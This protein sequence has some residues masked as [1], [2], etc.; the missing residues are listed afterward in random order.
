ME[1]ELMDTRKTTPGWRLL[2][3]YAVRVGGATNHRL[4]LGDMLL[5]KNNHVDAQQDKS[6]AQRMRTALRRIMK[7]KA[8]KIGLEV[9]VRDLEELRAALEFKVPRIMLDNMND[10]KVALAVEIVRRVAPETF[11]EVSGGVEMDRFKTLRKLGVNAVSMGSLTSQVRSVDISLRLES[12]I[13]QNRYS[14][15]RYHRKHSSS[16]SAPSQTRLRPR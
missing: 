3:K 11:I 7:A 5:V 16:G 2:E 14:A 9:E 15:R 13:S 1:I 8:R 12:P 10:R 4:S 6:R